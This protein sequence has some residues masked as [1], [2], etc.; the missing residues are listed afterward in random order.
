M[1][2][3]RGFTRKHFFIDRG[4]QGRYMMTFLIP[5]MILLAFMLFTLYFAAQMIVTTT[6]ATI[7]DNIQDKITY[8]FQDITEPTNEQ[9][10]MV[11][12]DIDSYLNGYSTSGAYRK[13]LL[14]SLMW[15]FG[16]GI[17]LVIIQITLLTIFFSHKLAGPIYRFE[18][19]CYALTEGD[20]LQ[21]IL[22]R[23]GDDLQNLASLF[24][25]AIETTRKRLRDLST[26]TD[27]NERKRIVQQLKIDEK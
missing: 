22:L 20:Y 4:L 5:M 6:T 15:V 24:N 19:A 12:K 23:K 25:K 1:A 9:Y 16:I 17:F 27:A 26:T 14:S 18:K 21:N 13:T 10:I 2:D 8:R 3:K 7:K 11:L